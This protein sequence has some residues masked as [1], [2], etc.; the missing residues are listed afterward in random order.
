[1]P[2]KPVGPR[3]TS[4][5][6]DSLG[7][8]RR[9]VFEPTARI[10]VAYVC[11]NQTPATEVPALINSVH[12]VISNI[13]NGADEANARATVLA[14]KRSVSDD[15]IVCLEDGKKL[16]T[17]RRYLQTRYQMTPEQYRAKWGLPY[18]YPMVA[19]AYA[20]FA[21]KMGLGRKQKSKK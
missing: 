12:A 15:Y 14:I 11:N 21:K 18:D 1:M 19:P 9:D 4:R 20:T 6:P 7:S 3:G 17:L 5:K 10:V 2:R 8:D 13:V 16:R